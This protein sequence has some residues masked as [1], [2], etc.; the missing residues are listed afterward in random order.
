MMM[1][2]YAPRIGVIGAGYW[3]EKLIRNC[4]ELGVLVAACDASAGR[5]E[6]IAA[7]YPQCAVYQNLEA[8]WDAPL[9]AVVI[10]TPAETHAELTHAAISHGKH[11]LV[12]K[13]LALLVEDGVAMVEHAHKAGVQL[14]VGHQLLY[15]PAFIALREA[16]RAGEIGDIR[17]IRSQRCSLGKLR[18][19]ESV[20]WSFAPHDLAVILSLYDEEPIAVA[21]SRSRVRGDGAADVAYADFVFPRGRSAHVTASWFDDRKLQITQVFGSRGIATFADSRQ[22]A[23]ATISEIA[24]GTD[25]YGEPTIERLGERLLPYQPSEPLENELRAFIH[26]I[27]HATPA[28]ASGEHG[29]SVLRA[30]SMADSVATTTEP[31]ERMEYQLR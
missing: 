27:A 29:L 26:A 31:I 5:L 1:T 11:V 6:A 22:G 17:H 19:R 4:S 14:C 12:E 30:L 9:D 16:V 13:P 10:A 8:F 2:A 21:A 24:L 23:T 7:R 18:S 25:D 20:W 28:L 3:G 15:H